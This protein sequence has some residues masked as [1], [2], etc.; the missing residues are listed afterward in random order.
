MKKGNII[1]TWR[2]AWIRWI[3]S[4]PRLVTD[5]VELLF[6]PHSLN[7][8]A[9][10]L[11]HC[12]SGLSA[13]TGS[14]CCAFQFCG[15][16]DDWVCGWECLLLL[17]C[18]ASWSQSATLSLPVSPSCLWYASIYFARF[19]LINISRSIS[20]PPSPL[21]PLLSGFYLLLLPPSPSPSTVLWSR[22]TLSY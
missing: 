19:D 3:I 17:V 8:A 2:W 1:F 22:T 18:S 16:L 21:P 13:S 6:Y 20:P 14:R 5:K 4:L 11:L 15:W 10:R 12:L 7:Q 9:L